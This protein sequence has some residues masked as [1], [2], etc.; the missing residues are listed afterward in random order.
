MSEASISQPSLWRRSWFHLLLGLLVVVIHVFLITQFLD[1]DF[2]TSEPTYSQLQA[3]L[4]A[5]MT[6]DEEQALFRW[7]FKSIKHDEETTWIIWTFD[8]A[9]YSV[10]FESGKATRGCLSKKEKS[11][12][13]PSEIIRSFLSKLGL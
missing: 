5:G 9:E 6:E 11:P 4:E 7:H 1:T 13:S 12:R 8:D 10:L 3:Q 2:G